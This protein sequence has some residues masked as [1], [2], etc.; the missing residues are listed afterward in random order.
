[1]ELKIVLDKKVKTKKQADKFMVNLFI[2]MEN[3]L[4]EKVSYMRVE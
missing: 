3:T 2:N 4:K 1:M